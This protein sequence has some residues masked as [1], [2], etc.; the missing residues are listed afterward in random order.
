MPVRHFIVV[1]H[2]HLGNLDVFC[3]EESW[4]Q[5]FAEAVSAAYLGWQH[6]FIFHEVVFSA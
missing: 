6:L 1:G 4:D 5:A 2:D 3:E